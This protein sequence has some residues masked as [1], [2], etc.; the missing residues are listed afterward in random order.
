[1]LQP[2][3]I[4]ISLALQQGQDLITS[5]I[6]CHDGMACD[7]MASHTDMQE[8]LKMQNAVELIHA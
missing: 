3:V 6:K 8:G 2:F 1:M 4:G 7:S 5:C